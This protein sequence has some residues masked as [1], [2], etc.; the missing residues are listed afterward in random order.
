MA[1]I[2]IPLLALGG[3]YV[4]SKNKKDNT[5]QPYS[6]Q[7]Q[8]QGQ[9]PTKEGYQNMNQTRN[10]L[11]GVNPPLADKNFPVTQSVSNANVNMYRNPNQHTDKYFNPA[12]FKNVENNNAKDF[13]VGG[14]AQTSFSLTGKPIEKDK[15]K[16]ANMVPFFGG[17]VRGATAEHNI[18]E[19]V[20]DNMQGSGS[21]YFT[22]KEQAPM[23]KPQ[24]GYQYANGAPN[25]SDFLQ[26]RVNPSLRMANVKPWEEERVAPGLNQGF[27]SS[28]GNSGYNSGMEA[29]EMWLD[30]TVDQLRVDT[31]PKTSYELAGHEGP[32]TYYNKTAPTAQTQGKVEKHL[33]DKYFVSGPE[34]WLTTTGLE[35]AQTA[36]GIEVLHD[37]NR[38][39]TTAEYYGS[40]ANQSE[41]TYAP[42]EY[43]KARRPVLPVQDYAS[44]SANGQGA[45]TTGDYGIKS[46]SNLS[47]N[48]S[49]TRHDLNVGP[50]NGFMKAI[51]SP[52][53]DFLRPSR[54]EDVVHNMRSS[55]NASAPVER[56]HIFNP[57]DR[58]KT[59]IREMTEAELDCN[60]LNVEHQS[61]NAYLVSKHQPVHVQ[62]DTT[63]VAHTGTAGPN[64]FSSSKSYEAE[65]N[66]H[67][68][69]NK[70]YEN[71]PNQGGTQIFNQQENIDIHRRDADRDN[72]R[73]WVPS[74]G[75]TAGITAHALPETFSRVKVSQGYDQ[76]VNTSRIAPDLLTAFKSNPYTQS[77]TS[78]A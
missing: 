26:S 68:N 36:R 53:M 29:R 55:G 33:P 57:A 2:A 35:K 28:G 8:G 46:Y 14:S 34:R 37:V 65:Y 71:R 56:G 4:V 32:G 78:W 18:T 38:T 76:N 9:F 20:L 15:F 50:V 6:G 67:N 72:N 45:A 75:G 3:M 19:S 62:R 25:M 64:G 43:Q 12:N 73:W 22:K 66:Q 31:N 77:L 48:R 44:I 70:T 63:N 60:H 40:R 39:N 69:V 13:G 23:F 27:T 5:P 51:V 47:N 42:Q 58:T 21:Q 10:M 54:K 49:T 1:E 41:G 24:D 30:K 74:S 11:P 59:T 7:G 52:V 17:K 61:A 16:H